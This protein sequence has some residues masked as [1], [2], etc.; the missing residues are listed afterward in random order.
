MIDIDLTFLA[1]VVNF[2]LLTGLLTLILYRPV[3]KLLAERADRIN[4]DM[5]K[6]R[7]DRARAQGLVAEYEEKLAQLQKEMHDR[8]EEATLRGEAAKEEILQKARDEARRILE[9]ASLEADRIRREAWIKLRDDLVDLTMA[10][11]AK[12]AA[13]GNI[14]VSEE[15]VRRALGEVVDAGGAGRC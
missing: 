8:I 13:S 7:E 15:E 1:T 9:S 10:A 6:A 14:A 11:C 2:L 5:A 4:N 3:K 12:V